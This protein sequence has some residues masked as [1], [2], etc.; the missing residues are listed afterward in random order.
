[1]LF[2]SKK[3]KS[4][5]QNLNPELHICDEV[6]LKQ[7]VFHFRQKVLDYVKDQIQNKGYFHIDPLEWLVPISSLAQTIDRLRKN[8]IQPVFCFVYDEYW[9]LFYQLHQLIYSVLGDY[10]KL[11]A[12]WA[13]HVDPSKSES[14]WG[15]HRDQAGSLDKK[16]NPQHLSIWIPLTEATKLNGCIHV[17]PADK[18]PAY[19]IQTA[20][21]NSFDR[22]DVTVLAATA[23]SVLGWTGELIHWGGTASPA[24]SEPRI[25]VSLEFQQQDIVPFIGTAHQYN[26]FFTFEQR[27][28]FIRE[29]SLRY[30][31]MDQYFPM[32]VQPS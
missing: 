22:N 32:S 4:F 17:V 26:D 23:G 7:D 25:S 6:F 16:G 14:G 29:Q 8:K 20:N 24:A 30:R 10:V 2:R 12:F 13:W 28:E 21:R 27:L 31:H 3:E 1:M 19:N 18:D 9:L 15:I 5:W 11:S